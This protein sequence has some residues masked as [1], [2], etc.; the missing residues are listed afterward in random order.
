MATKDKNL[1]GT[2]S[3]SFPNRKNKNWC[4][5]IS[6]WNEKHYIKILDGSLSE[7]LKK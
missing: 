2:I 1:S 6:E 7:T 4:C 3:V 5:C